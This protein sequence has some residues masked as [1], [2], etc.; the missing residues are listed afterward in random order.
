MGA[1]PGRSHCLLKQYRV[2]VDLLGE[3]LKVFGLKFFRAFHYRSTAPALL[4]YSGQ[5]GSSCPKGQ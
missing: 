2:F 3:S 1:G 5:V 4:A